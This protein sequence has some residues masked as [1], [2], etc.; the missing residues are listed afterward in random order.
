LVD[1]GAK[2]L[3]A[4]PKVQGLERNFVGRGQS[5]FLLK[6]LEVAGVLYQN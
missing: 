1:A 5:D 3:L 4:Q 6:G 2:S